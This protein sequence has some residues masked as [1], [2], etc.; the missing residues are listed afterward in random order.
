M[1]PRIDSRDLAASC[2]RDVK[3]KIRD[4][5]NEPLVIKPSTRAMKNRRARDRSSIRIITF[6]RRII[7]AVVKDDR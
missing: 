4:T 3:I 5:A 6:R 7:K 1:S 2:S